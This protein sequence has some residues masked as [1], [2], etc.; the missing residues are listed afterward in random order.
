VLL[1]AAGAALVLLPLGQVLRYQ[2]ADL[3]ALAAERAA[4]DPMAQV[5][6]VQR[7]VLAHRDTADRVLRGRH[8]LESERRERQGELDQRLR[9]LQDTLATGWW[10]RALQESQSLGAD[11]RQLARQV[12]LRQI[13]AN[14]SLNGHQLLMEQA[15]QVL[16]LAQVAAPSGTG[17]L[18]VQA[19]QQL[20]GEPGFSPADRQRALAALEAAL[21]AQDSALM[22]R[23]AQVREQ[24][25][26]LW[27]A[28]GAIGALGAFTACGLALGAR[29]R[30]ARA[31]G[32]TGS[33]RLA[34]DEDSAL[35]RG[36]GRRATDAAPV[37]NNAEPLLQ[38]LRGGELPS[39]FEPR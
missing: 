27:L 9:Q 11:W 26:A 3:T 37:R 29:R 13:N 5:V 23:E 38:R 33:D 39:T 25:A 36:H 34:S 10:L 32:G 18:V 16:D 22:T 20:Q 7:G 30:H 6:G 21:R 15:I 12:A 8:A 35:R 19:A 28:I 4:L 17:A 31:L 2:S 14:T 24:Q 1:G